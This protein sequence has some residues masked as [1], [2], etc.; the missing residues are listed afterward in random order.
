M[1]IIWNG[2]QLNLIYL[3]NSLLHNYK[4]KCTGNIN[5][6][7][8]L[9]HKQAVLFI[10]YGFGTGWIIKLIMADETQIESNE[11]VGMK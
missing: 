3:F 11:L 7:V 10:A 9:S 6:N 8:N 5:I 2:E 4:R 1:F